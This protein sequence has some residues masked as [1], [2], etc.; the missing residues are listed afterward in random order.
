MRSAAGD[1]APAPVNI[2]FSNSLHLRAHGVNLPNTAP[3]AAGSVQLVNAFPGVTLAP[4]AIASP[5]GETQR[6]FVVEREAKIKL[7]ANVTAPTPSASVFLDLQAMLAARGQG[8]TIDAGINGEFGLLG[9]AF[10]PSYAQNRQFFIFYSVNIA[11]THYERLSR[12]TARADNAN[13]ADTSSE[14]ILIDQLDRE[15][16]HNGG[17][18]HFGPMAA[19][20]CRSAMKEGNMTCGRTASASTSISVRADRR[21]QTTRQPRA[22][23]ASRLA[24]RQRGCPLRRA[25]GQSVHRRFQLQWRP[26]IPRRCARYSWGCGLRN[27][28]R[29]SF[30]PLNGDLWLGDVGQ[31]SYEEINL[32]TK[33][34]NY[35][36]AAREGTHADPAYRRLA[37]VPS[38]RNSNT[39]IS[40]SAAIC[41]TRETR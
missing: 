9:L 30:D 12:M 10:H 22:E 24:A 8:E 25:A 39:R 26:S 11:G 38:I 40:I 20:T 13:L 35:G 37:S 14:L 27:P 2:T 1:S 7:I 16:N 19:S 5:P 33:G 3:V 36:W 31:D 21:G 34:G 29:F 28:W 32:I 23:P 41:T 18:L 17:D 15:P 6:L 4:V